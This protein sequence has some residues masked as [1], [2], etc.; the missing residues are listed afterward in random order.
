MMATTTLTLACEMD[1]IGDAIADLQ[2]I[3]EALATCH[4]SA[5]RELERRIEDLV[6]GGSFSAPKSH[7]IGGG[8]I[9]F[10]P[11]EEFKAIIADAR[12]LG[13]I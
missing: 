5:Y 11:P 1:L 3:F 2:T 10:E 13:V 12:A 4:G 7:W 6:G 8:R 9:V